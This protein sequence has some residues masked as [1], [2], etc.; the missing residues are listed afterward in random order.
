MTLSLL[1]GSKIIK[2]FPS[3]AGL[4]RGI[5]SL[6]ISS[7]CVTNLVFSSKTFFQD[8]S[9][10]LGFLMKWAVCPITGRLIPGGQGICSKG[11]KQ[12]ESCFSETCVTVRTKFCWTFLFEMLN[13]MD[14]MLLCVTAVVGCN[15]DN[16]VVIYKRHKRHLRR[17][18]H[19]C[20]FWH[21]RHMCYLKVNKDIAM[22]S[23]WQIFRLGPGFFY[24]S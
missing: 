16:I 12:I 14:L 5:F 2:S 13:A 9:N 24:R 3:P 17:Y 4:L 23:F 6:I 18:C 21:V 11:F 19:V 10:P 15:F 8:L 20:R 22:N 1:P 7:P